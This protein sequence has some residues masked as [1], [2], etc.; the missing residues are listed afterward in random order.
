MKGYIQQ[1]KKG[2]WRIF[3]SLGR[4]PVTGKYKRHTCTY[5]AE[6][7]ED[8]EAHLVKL[9]HQLNIGDFVEPS[10]LTF[11]GFL[12]RWLQ[13]S[14][15]GDESKEWY[16]MVVDKHIK[17]ILGNVRL[18][19]LSPLHIQSYFRR[20]QRLDGKGDSLSPNTLHGHF[21]V[22]RAA[23]NQAVE[24]GLLS[25]NP[26]KRAK[27]PKRTQ[28]GG[29]ALSPEEFLRFYAIAENMRYGPLYLIAIATGMRQG[30]LLGLRWDSV[31]L[32][33]GL[34]SVNQALKKPGRNPKFGEPKTPKS[35]R[36]VRIPEHA[37]PVF[38]KLK[39]RYEEEREFYVEDRGLVFCTKS[40]NPVAK[41]D[42]DRRL[43]ILLEKAGVQRIRFHD[44]RH[45]NATWLLLKGVDL[46]T[47]QEHLGHA[48]PNTTIQIY[49]HVLAALSR[50][51]AR[52]FDSIL[53]DANR[54][55]GLE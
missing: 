53:K 4:D 8:A 40:G 49:G 5:H 10:K 41:T 31:D 46:K 19:K 28:S 29:R 17:P 36:L 24:W 35:R 2:V 55:P 14:S 54:S 26:A 50:E 32:D 3:I 1:R 21:R 7:R 23:L 15:L 37:V 48:D 38:E 34:I 45:C 44:L 22:I 47:V 6:K 25:K 27:P 18:D 16:R 13:E 11:G 51:P 20:V 39:A 30:E 33:A 9:L 12:D 43:K 42:I 52:T